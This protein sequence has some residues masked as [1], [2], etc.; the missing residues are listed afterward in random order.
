MYQTYSYIYV[1]FKSNFSFVFGWVRSIFVSH[2]FHVRKEYA[3]HPSKAG[4]AILDGVTT[5]LLTLVLFPKY[6]FTKI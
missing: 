3:L 2:N 6:F 1:I 4:P 5:E